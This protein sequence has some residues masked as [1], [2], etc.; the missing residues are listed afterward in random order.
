MRQETES[1]ARREFLFLQGPITPF[2]TRMGARLR[3][4]GHG[5]HRINL[6]L[7]DKLSW[8]GPGAV[9]FTGRPGDW[10]A[11]IA[12]FLDRHGITDI[13]LLGEQRLYHR[14]AIA[15]ARARGIA[16]V[17]T[18]FGYIRPDW[19]TFEFNGLGRDSLFPR[20]PAAILALAEDLPPPDLATRYRDS[21]LNQA[22][23]DVAYHF[24]SLI[25][26][27][28]RHY[29]SHQIYH[30]LQVYLGTL[31]RIL[32][33]RRANRRADGIIARLKG[34]GPLFLMAMQ[35]ETDF[36]V[37]AYSAYSD[38]DTAIEEVTR[39]FAAHAPADA[40]LLFKV[41]P[42]DPAMKNWRRRV[43]RIAGRAGVA[44][45]VHYLGGG[46]LGDI[47]ESVQG[48][49]TINSTVGLRAIVDRLPTHALGEAL[50][51]IPGLTH[52]GPLDR[53]WTEGRPP[54]PELREAF[55]RGIAWC[56][57]IRGVY[58]AQPGL[59][60]AVEAAV[61]RLHNRLVNRPVLPGRG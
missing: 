13:V 4:L 18:D 19:I 46:N 17:A 33:R 12:A 10:P 28:F 15:A 29:E 43:T 36:S 48:V 26:G 61:H 2:F 49:I 32:T 22:A 24:V 3:E 14:E 9:D 31:S 51:K 5:V 54:D 44:E 58:Y 40:Q 27:F 16:V 41:H 6:C 50:Y 30:P 34:R 37:R 56:L 47:T 45:R 23:W 25:P 53:F 39:S 57:Q 21:F 60:A 8:R 35:M 38:L 11:Y 55:L 42:L 20:D 52:D 7:G 59:D 1:T